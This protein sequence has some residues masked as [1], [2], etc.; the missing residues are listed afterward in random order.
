MLVTKIG[1]LRYGSVRLPLRR[2][3]SLNR[4]YTMTLSPATLSNSEPMR[5]TVRPGRLR[6]RIFR[7]VGLAAVALIFCLSGLF[8]A[9]FPEAVG[10]LFAASRSGRSDAFSASRAGAVIRKGNVNEPAV[11]ISREIAERDGSKQSVLP[12]KSKNPALSQTSWNCLPAE[13]FEGRFY[14]AN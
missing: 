2:V 11:R 1:A 6:E 3:L 7:D 4:A 9:A 8:S 13:G 5:G 10:P 12:A 14:L